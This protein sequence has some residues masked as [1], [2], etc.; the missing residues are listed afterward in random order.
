MVDFPADTLEGIEVMSNS[1]V[2]ENGA[3][4]GAMREAMQSL[5]N[6]SGGAPGVVLGNTA[7]NGAPLIS[8][9]R[10]DRNVSFKLWDSQLSIPEVE[11][12][13]LVKI[14]LQVDPKTKKK[15]RESA[16]MMAPTS[17]LTEKLICESMESVAQFALGWL[18]GI[19]DKI[20]KD[21]YLEGAD[22]F[23][24]YELSLPLLLEK[25]AEMEAGSRL[26]KEDIKAWFSEYLRDPIL[27]H[28]TD[29]LGITSDTAANDGKLEK[30]G[31]ILG[32]YEVKFEKL[33][34]K[35]AIAKADCEAL[36]EIIEF[37][38]VDSTKLGRR[39]MIRLNDLVKPDEEL[40]EGL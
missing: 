40:L 17:H 34:G 31:K 6:N 10:D 35:S 3:N 36:K 18:Q 25:M 26:K 7:S 1:E 22:S 27:I 16:Y 39:L 38:E 11:G 14:A 21:A 33:A 8:P 23:D 12:Q 2:V 9:I 15:K 4:S 32:N 29:K 24:V 19:E 20:I 13:R 37:F 5:D 28:F 30:L